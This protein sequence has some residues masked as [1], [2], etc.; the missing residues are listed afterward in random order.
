MIIREW[1]A[2]ASRSKAEAYPQHF[3][4]NVVPELRRVSGFLAAHLS[5]RLVDGK[6]EFLVLT[7][8]RSMDAVRTFAGADAD[9]AV[10]EPEAV[11]ALF[12]YDAN[13]QHYHVMEEVA[14]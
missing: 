6:I 2:R 11:A 9:K 5:K 14:A 8:W 4:D 7:W 3:R 12:E 10:V 1:R 13:V